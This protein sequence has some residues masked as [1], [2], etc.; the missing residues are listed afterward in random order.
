MRRI[1]ISW[2]LYAGMPSFPGDPPFVREPV[3][4][5]ARGDPYNLSAIR[6][7]T[8]AGTHVDP[9]I[10]FVAGGAT[11]DRVDLDQL[12]GPCRVVDVPASA[13]SVGPAEVGALP[14]GTERVLFRTSNSP[15]WQRRP[16]YFPE[17]VAVAP[18]AAH[19]LLARGVRVVG[20]DSL[21]IERDST[22]TFPVHHAL[23]GGGALIVEGLLLAEAPAGNYELECFPLK[24]RDGDGGPARAALRTEI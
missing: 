17:Y 10:H 16:E 13:T 11:I 8:H 23:L 1:D 22:G 6:L 14:P 9:P 2:S 7:G 19:P 3:R 12:N 24:L 5:I 4:S 18:T 15:K 21:S 20:I